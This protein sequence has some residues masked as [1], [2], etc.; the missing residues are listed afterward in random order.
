MRRETVQVWQIFLV[1]N[2]DS[3]FDALYS[4]LETSSFKRVTKLE[5][6]LSCEFLL[7][8]IH[9]TVSYNQDCIGSV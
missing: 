9:N 7:S 2:P 8:M 6:I 3:D 1:R 4:S 5:T